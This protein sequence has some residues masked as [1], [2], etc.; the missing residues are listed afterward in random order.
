ML[1][2]VQLSVAETTLAGPSAIWQ[3]PAAGSCALLH[4]DLLLQKTAL[5]SELMLV[6][7]EWWQGRLGERGPLTERQSQNKIGY[8]TLPYIAW[9]IFIS[10]KQSVSQ[11]SSSHT[12]DNWPSQSA[13][14]I[15]LSAV[16][17]PESVKARK[18]QIYSRSSSKAQ[19]KTRDCDGWDIEE[20]D[21][22]SSRG[23]EKTKLKRT[24]EDQQSSG[25][26]REED[27]PLIVEKLKT[28]TKML[29]KNITRQNDVITNQLETINKQ[30]EKIKNLEERLEKLESRLSEQE[31]EE[32]RV[33]FAGLD[34]KREEEKEDEALFKKRVLGVVSKELEH[35]EYVCHIVEAIQT[36]DA[37]L[38]EVRKF[39]R[40]A[41]S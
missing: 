37:E 17:A 2:Q 13:D 41:F 10:S 14:G 5:S 12:R 40:Q 38:D 20:D 22:G 6:V 1:R 11:M 4:L 30:N 27:L 8:P 24:D 28:N 7:G 21:Q 31:Q 19:S 36:L 32:K 26:T 23:V 29:I 25:K 18:M 35:I 16:H 33:Q 34:I 15:R 39:I 3:E 9:L